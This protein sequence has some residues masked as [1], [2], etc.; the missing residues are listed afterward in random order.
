MSDAGDGSSGDLLDDPFEHALLAARLCA[1]DLGLGGMALHGGGEWR[2]EIIA[3]LRR[4]LGA[5]APLKRIPN[6]VDDE[7]LLGG[8]DL[9]ATLPRARQSPSAACWRRP[10]AG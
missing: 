2:D 1:I 6:H 4:G 8:L 9:T 10:R 3:E 5:D 7:R